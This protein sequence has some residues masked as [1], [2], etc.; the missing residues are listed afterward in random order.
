M[1]YDNRRRLLLSAFLARCCLLASC[2]QRELRDSELVQDTFFFAEGVKDLLRD[3]DPDLPYVISGRYVLWHKRKRYLTE[4]P[5]CLPCHVTEA[6]RAMAAVRPDKYPP[7]LRPGQKPTVFHQPP[8]PPAGCPCT[9]DLACE[10]TLNVTG[11][12]ESLSR[13]RP[14]KWSPESRLYGLPGRHYPTVCDYP[15]FHGGSGVLISVGAMRQIP[16]KEALKCYYDDLKNMSAKPLSLKAEAHG[17][18]LAS[19]CFWMNGIAITDPGLSL[20]QHEMSNH[21]G[22]VM[23]ARTANLQSLQEVV[24]NT[25]ALHADFLQVG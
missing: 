14:L 10:Y 22:R 11:E 15:H 17:D 1:T 6:Y 25:A 20:S 23:D 2:A 19:L 8:V 9:P 7:H 18:R 13:K 16:L 21:P 12:R 5:R 24:D 3:Y 4:A